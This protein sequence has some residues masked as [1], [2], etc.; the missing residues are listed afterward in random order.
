MAALAEDQEVNV[1]RALAARHMLP[2][3]IRAPLAGDPASGVRSVVACQS[4]TPP[5]ILAKLA[6]DPIA[7]GRRP[8][9]PLTDVRGSVD[10]VRY[11]AATVAV[12]ASRC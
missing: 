7:R 9:T 2:H 3:E 12:F 5:E 10:C 6:G 1:R 8:K 4:L 11:R